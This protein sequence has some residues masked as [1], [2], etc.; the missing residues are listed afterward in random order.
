MVSTPA[1]KVRARARLFLEEGQLDQA[2]DTYALLT[3]LNSEDIHSLLKIA[4]IQSRLGDTQ[5]AADTFGRVAAHYCSQGA[6]LKGL[7][8]YKQ[9]L[10]MCPERLDVHSIVAKL[11]EKLGLVAEATTHRRHL[12]TVYENQG[13]MDECVQVLE[14]LLASDQTHVAARI[15]L[16]EFY[17]H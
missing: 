12:V 3:E 5:E 8:V 1:D 9:L 14:D 15:K 13:R 16:A 17:V 4:E 7:A 10:V 2:L 11:Y 6:Y